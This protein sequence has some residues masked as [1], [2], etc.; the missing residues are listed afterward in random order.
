MC[1]RIARMRVT[2]AW[3]KHTTPARGGPL[4][5]EWA[6]LVHWP[7]R[8]RA[9]L[10]GVMQLRTDRAPHHRARAV[11]GESAFSIPC[12]LNCGAP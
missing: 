1:E 5:V 2:R 8:F 6:I 4:E 10:P 9:C 12:V 11:R 3:P 7:H